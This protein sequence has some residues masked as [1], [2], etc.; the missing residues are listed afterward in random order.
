[1]RNT[2]DAL[3]DVVEAARVHHCYSTPETTSE[4]GTAFC[5]LCEALARLDEEECS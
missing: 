5:P 3:L 1:M 4:E 2:L